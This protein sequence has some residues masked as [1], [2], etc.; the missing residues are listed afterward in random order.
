MAFSRGATGVS[1]L[2]SCFEVILEVTV[3]SV[4]GN[5]A[6]SRL[7]RDIRVFSNC[8]TMPGVPLE[9]QGE[10]DLILRCDRNVRTPFQTKQ[11]NGPSSRDEEGK[12]GLFLSRGGKL[13]V[14]LKWRRVCLGT[15]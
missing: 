4:Q 10:T 3:D 5:Q 9:F 14:P 12:K 6:L 1:Q 7:D 11:G 15:S 8:G 2:P 13:S